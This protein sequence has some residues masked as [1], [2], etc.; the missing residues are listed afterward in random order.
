MGGFG[1]EKSVEQVGGGSEILIES[2][3]AA[4]GTERWGDWLRLLR[5]HSGSAPDPIGQCYR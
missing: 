2:S 1:G 4:S 5:A 3:K